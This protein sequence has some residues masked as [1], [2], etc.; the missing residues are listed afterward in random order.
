M[1]FMSKE[2]STTKE[3]DQIDAKILQDLLLDGRKTFTQIAKE[4]GEKKSTISKRFKDL[5]ESGVITGATIQL[6]YAALG[7]CAV[8]SIYFKIRPEN[9]D[10]SVKRILEVPNIYHALKYENDTV[11]NV[12]ATLKTIIEFNRVKELILKMPTVSDL[13]TN[14]WM[15]IRNTPH[16]L[17]IVD[18]CTLPGEVSKKRSQ[19]PIEIDETDRKIIEKLSV[20]GRAPFATVAKELG[21]ATNTVIRKFERLKESGII[22]VSIQVNPGKLGYRATAIFN[23]AFSQNSISS[24]V[25]KLS[26][27]PNIY[28]IIKTS[29]QFDLAVFY[30]LKDIDH[31]I[32][33]QAEI[34]KIAEISKAQMSVRLPKPVFPGR[35]EYISTF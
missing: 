24:I 7:Y 13:Q 12:V 21:V 5:Q 33:I 31:L 28:L 4:C 23:L 17:Q 2:P 35:K 10:S 19:K 26:A 9:I 22:N 6:D 20:D 15:G 29:G 25:E 14:V 27:I 34:A 8:G 1:R 16:N 18:N 30:L 3:L 32:E 11:V